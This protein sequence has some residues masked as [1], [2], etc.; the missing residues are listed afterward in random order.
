MSARLRNFLAE[1]SPSDGD[2]Q[3]FKPFQNE[4]DA[5]NRLIDSSR[6]VEIPKKDSSIMDV[7]RR[8]QKI[9]RRSQ[10]PNVC[11]SIDDTFDSSSLIGPYGLFKKKSNEI[12]HIKRRIV[13]TNKQKYEQE[14]VCKALII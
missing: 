7:L 8:I 3:G 2:E 14:V 12:K 9:Q 5:L 11:L 6:T 13:P 10:V 1:P 4:R